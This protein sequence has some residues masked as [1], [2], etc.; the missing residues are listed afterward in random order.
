LEAQIAL[1]TLARRLV[2]PRPVADPPPYREN[3]SLCGPRHLVVA[4]DCL[5]D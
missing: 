2:G 4:V 3:A 1:R 5:G